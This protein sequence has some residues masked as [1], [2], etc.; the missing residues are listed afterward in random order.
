MSKSDYSLRVITKNECKNILDGWHYLSKLSKGFKSGFNYGLFH[1][2]AL[3]GVCIFTGFPVPELSKGLFGL[4]R[5]DQDGLFELSRLCVSPHYQQ[6][7]HNITSWFVARALKQLRR[8]TKVRCVLSYA[9]G[10]Y[11]R[12]TIYRACNFKYYG[13]ST[14]KKD[15][16][17]QQSDGSFT[18]HSRGKTKGVLG[19][20]RD[21]SIK[22]RYLI[23]YDKKLKPLW[24]EKI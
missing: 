18:K 9:D 11:H 1:H 13:M 24:D 20:W 15:F 5:S 6:S 16:W 22:H 21:R 4:D 3:I 10:D 19:E 2:D 17:V 23:V 8:D 12:G 7:E 14:P